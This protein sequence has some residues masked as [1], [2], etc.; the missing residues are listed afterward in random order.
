MPFTRD[1]LR[2]LQENGDIRKYVSCCRGSPVLTLHPQ[3][4][5]PASKREMSQFHSEDYIE[6][7]HRITP[8]NMNLFAKEQVKCTT[9]G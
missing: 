1:E 4:A 8:A 5:K 7:L 3:R 2:S 9:D 6:F